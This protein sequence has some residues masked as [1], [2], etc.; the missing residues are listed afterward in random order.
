MCS[1]WYGKVD[2]F[3]IDHKDIELMK[4]VMFATYRSKYKLA[5]A[6]KTPYA[7]LL[8]KMKKLEEYKMITC[9]PRKTVKKNG[10]PDKRQPET[11]DITI[12]G[13]A[14]LIVNNHLKDADLEKALTRLFNSNKKLRDFRHLLK[15]A[16]YQS[17]VAPSVIEAILALRPKINFLCFNEAYVLELFIPLLEVAFFKRYEKMQPRT[18]EEAVRFIRHIGKKRI[19]EWCKMSLTDAKLQKQMA[20]N[21]IQSYRMVLKFIRNIR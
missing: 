3:E 16:E 1:G 2:R 5:E 12:K 18:R 19:Y 4:T 6:T 14:Y 21:K 8:R 11:W 10:T 7:N 9:L 17:V 20:E 15:M 13:L